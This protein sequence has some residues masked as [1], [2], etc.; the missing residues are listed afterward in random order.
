MV[1]N[2][3]LFFITSHALPLHYSI[4]TFFGHL[5]LTKQIAKCHQKHDY[6]RHQEKHMTKTCLTVQE[7]RGSKINHL[8]TSQ[9]ISYAWTNAKHI[10]TNII[11]AANA[12]RNIYTIFSP[13]LTDL[14]RQ[15]TKYRIQQEYATNMTPLFL[16]KALRRKARLMT[17][18][19]RFVPLLQL[20]LTLKK[21]P[22][23]A[24]IYITQIRGVLGHS[25]L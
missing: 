10:F 11:I 20:F 24:S 12:I 1:K 22:R 15:N 14:F 19:N 7:K 18:T 13:R 2:A 16:I 5:Y 23:F 3:S 4:H 8:S 9:S 25:A 6:D 17:H 21:H